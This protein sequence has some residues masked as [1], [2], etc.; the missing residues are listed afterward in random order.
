MAESTQLP[1]PADPESVHIID[2]SGYIFRAYH[3]LPP[4]SSSRGEPT[5]AVRGVVSMLMKLFEE[6]KPTRICV[7]VDARG[8][9][10][11]RDRFPEYKANRD[12]PPPD[13]DQQIKRVMEV[14]RAF[15]LPLLEVQGYEADD[16]IAALV[17]GT[18][19][20]GLKS[21]I[22]SADKDL[23]QLVGEG[24]VMYDTMR[25]RVFGTE[26]TIAKF[27]VPPNQVRDLLALM[28]DSSDNVPGVPSVGVKTAAKLLTAHGSLDGIYENLDAV[29]G[30]AKAKLE[31]FKDQAYLSRELV[32]LH[33]ELE[34][35]FDAAFAEWGG[36][37]GEA[38]RRLF[39]EMEFNRLLNDLK[40]EAPKATQVQTVLSKEGLA[41]LALEIRTAGRFAF[42]SVLAGGFP[43]SADLVGLSIN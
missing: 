27:G 41:A 4:L 42:E 11:R 32:A 43:R 13:L 31:E 6:R 15:G 25:D 38:I 36:G 19:A 8:R 26:E 30:R 10:V 16:V 23:L 39:T 35:D 12:A 22:V 2:I 37:D 29:K 14:L 33:E 28:G 1:A 40:A 21:V 24:V 7:A 5:H 17:K 18:K 34:L 9:S 3:A 20:R